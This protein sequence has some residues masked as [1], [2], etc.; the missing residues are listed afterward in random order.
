[1]IAST[2]G[3]AIEWYDFFLYSVVTGLV[4]AKLFFPKSDP[5]IGTLE[6]FA[7]YAVGFVARPIGAGDLRPLRRPD[8]AQVHADRHARGDG[9]RHLRC[10][11]RADL[12]QHRDL[13]R[14]HP[15][16]FALHPGRG[17]RRRVGRVGSHVHGMGSL[18]ETRGFIASWPQFGV[19]CGLFLANWRCSPSA[20]FGRAIPDLGLAHPVSAEPH[21]GRGGTLHPARHPRDAGVRSPRRG[22]ARGAGADPAG[23]QGTAEDDPAPA[24]ARLAEQAPFT[25]SPPTSSP[26]ESTRSSSRAIS[27][28][29]PFLSLRS[30]RSSRSPSSD[31]SRIVS[32]ARTSTWPE[33]SLP[34]SS[35][36][37]ILGCSTPASPR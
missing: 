33:R 26:T 19:P 37:S 24:F 31:I 11:V 15:H 35:A 21:P 22:A 3:T 27:F 9:H 4:F 20:S 10:G 14:R 6:A 18:R 25:S 36:S 32:G 1:M 13:G 23:D 12:R 7:I 2:I 29:S 5:L 34:A 16:H 8:R 30:S 17:R 28:S